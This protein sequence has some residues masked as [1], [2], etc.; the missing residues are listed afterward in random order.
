MQRRASGKSYP[1]GRRGPRKSSSVSKSE[2]VVAVKPRGSSPARTPAQFGPLYIQRRV[3]VSPEFE[4]WVRGLG[5]PD[6]TPFEAMHVTVCYSTAPLQ[7]PEPDRS[8]LVLASPERRID[9]FG[10][11]LVLVFESP[12]LT[13]RTEHLKALGASYD[14]PK[15]Q[16]HVT[17][18][19]DYPGDAAAL[20]PFRGLLLLTGEELAVLDEDWRP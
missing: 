10:S 6:P 7:W 17:L 2:T 19:Y 12:F 14:F 16:P 4:D 15:Y 1:Y 9:Q 18:C 20:Q 8:G 11:A 3:I 5:L 13:A